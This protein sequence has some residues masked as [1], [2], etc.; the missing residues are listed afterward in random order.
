M[1]DDDMEVEV[2]APADPAASLATALIVLTTIML[3]TAT[4]TTLKILG[5]QYQE[6]MLASK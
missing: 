2:A 5:D 6:G 3:L 4:I 1:A